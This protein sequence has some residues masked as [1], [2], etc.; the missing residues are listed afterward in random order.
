MAELISSG[1]YITGGKN[2]IEKMEQ[3]LT[4][5]RELDMTGVTDEFDA[6][7][8]Y[9]PEGTPIILDAGAYK[10]LLEADKGA[11]AD[12]PKVIGFLYQE[13]HKDQPFASICVRGSVNESK[14]PFA[15]DAS[16]K[17]ALAGAIT[18]LP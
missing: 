7:Q 3:D 14:L 13:V 10:P 4:G 6:T 1:S 18:F 9:I 5:G 12:G 17:T 15:L 2:V 8:G 16:S 11:G